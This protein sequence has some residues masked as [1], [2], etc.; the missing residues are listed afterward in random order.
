MLH[1]MMTA[2]LK[3]IVKTNEITLNI[4]IGIG[5]TITHTCLS[6]EIYNNGYLVLRKNI[7]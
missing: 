6:R 1:F 4:G 3:N 2:C 7:L 5:D